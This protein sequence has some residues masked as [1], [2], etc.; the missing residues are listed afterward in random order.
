MIVSIDRHRQPIADVVAAV[1]DD[2]NARPDAVAVARSVF[3]RVLLRVVIREVQRAGGVIRKGIVVAGGADRRAECAGRGGRTRGVA[4]CIDRDNAVEAGC[5][6]RRGCIDVIA[7]RQKLRVELA[8][9]AAGGIAAVDVIAG[10]IRIA[11]VRPVDVDAVEIGDGGDRRRRGR[12]I[13]V[14]AARGTRAARG[15][16]VAVHIDGRHAIPPDDAGG[17][18]RVGVD[19]TAQD[20]AV[21]FRVRAELRAG[22]GI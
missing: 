12:R 8:K 9:R 19:R 21:Q 10:Q 15:G 13:R 22:R 7:A 11:V 1:I 20:P 5:S 18:G 17:C 6:G 14:I 3:Q 16:F 4:G 2:L